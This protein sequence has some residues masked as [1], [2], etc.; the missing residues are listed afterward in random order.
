MLIMV[1]ERSAALGFGIHALGFVLQHILSLYHI[2]GD[3][4]HVH[5]TMYMCD[6]C[7]IVTIFTHPT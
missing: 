3:T 7:T 4:M 1:D 6:M 2:I 5:P